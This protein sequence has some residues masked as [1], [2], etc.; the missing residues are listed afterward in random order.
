MTGTFVQTH[1]P[2]LHAAILV[3]NTFPLNTVH[4][5]AYRHDSFDDVDVLN[6][7]LVFPSQ[8][9]YECRPLC[10]CLIQQN[11]AAKVGGQG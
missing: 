6:C 3:L 5:V 1:P 11:A 4:H 9:C 7:T 2:A 10:S 8:G